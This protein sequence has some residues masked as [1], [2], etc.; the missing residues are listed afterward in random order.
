MLEGKTYDVVIANINRNILLRDIPV[1]VQTLT[2][3][4]VLLLSGFYQ[5]DIPKIREICEAHSLKY[6]QNLE[7]NHWVAVKF[8]N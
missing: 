1:Y 4:G 3:G 5:D 6:V 2:E 7:K 8:I